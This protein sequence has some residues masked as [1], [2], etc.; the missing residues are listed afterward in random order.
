MTATTTTTNAT[1]LWHQTAATTLLA[2]V[3]VLC[4]GCEKSVGDHLQV[5][6][7]HESD[8]TPKPI[9]AEQEDGSLSTVVEA[10]I[11]AQ[12]RVTRI[13]GSG[14]WY[15][16]SYNDNDGWIHEDY[17]FN[18]SATWRGVIGFIG[19]IAA[20]WAVFHNA[21]VFKALWDGKQKGYLFPNSRPGAIDVFLFLPTHAYWW[22]L[23]SLYF[24]SLGVV[25]QYQRIIEFLNDPKLVDVSIPIAVFYVSA[26]SF[27]APML[28]AF[29]TAHVVAGQ[30][31]AV[32]GLAI[33]H[34]GLVA[35]VFYALIQVVIIGLATGNDNI[36]Q[37]LLTRGKLALPIVSFVFTLARFFYTVMSDAPQ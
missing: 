2:C 8:S 17:V 16:V 20:I 5:R 9:V 4:A 35:F 27:P 15:W 18:N 21:R 14:K 13:D 10:P 30:T 6:K 31:D 12:L 26:I 19:V 36:T 1:H 33:I 7:L 23:G 3:A 34:V 11:G 25:F 29:I 22:W 28:L 32:S 37:R 24:I